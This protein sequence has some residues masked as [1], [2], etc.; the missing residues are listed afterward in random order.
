MWK[1]YQAYET[2]VKNENETRASSK[3]DNQWKSPERFIL[4]MQLTA[5]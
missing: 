4:M 5:A 1:R 3:S 2:R